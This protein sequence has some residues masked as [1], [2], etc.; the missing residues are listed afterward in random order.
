[1]SSYGIVVI[2]VTY[3]MVWSIMP[4]IRNMICVQET[5]HNTSQNETW[6]QTDRNKQMWLHIFL[7]IITKI[8]VLNKFK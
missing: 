2:S 5:V 6:W 7:G 8:L 4:L 1:M 3:P